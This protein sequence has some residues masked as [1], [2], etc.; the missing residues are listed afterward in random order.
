[1]QRH[2]QTDRLPRASGFRRTNLTIDSTR[3]SE[4]ADEWLPPDERKKQSPAAQVSSCFVVVCLFFLFAPLCKRVLSIMAHSHTEHRKLQ[5][6]PRSDAMRSDL[7]GLLLAPLLTQQRQHRRPE[8]VSQGG[9]SSLSG[10]CS[11]LT[12]PSALPLTTTTTWPPDAAQS[13]SNR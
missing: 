9:R 12:P 1:M 5:T 6:Y 8:Q 4:R 10:C 3:T 7:N 2:K 13:T 11:L